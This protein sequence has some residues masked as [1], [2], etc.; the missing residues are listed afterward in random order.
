MEGDRAVFCDAPD[1]KYINLYQVFNASSNIFQF[2]QHGHPGIGSFAY[3][4]AYIRGS[5][6][7]GQSQSQDNAQLWDNQ[8]PFDGNNNFMVTIR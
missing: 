4:S 7:L 3:I 5:P 6:S 1:K 8:Q 2:C